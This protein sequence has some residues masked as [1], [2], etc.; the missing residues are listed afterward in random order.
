M[1]TYKLLQRSRTTDRP[2]HPRV[3]ASV[4]FMK[5]G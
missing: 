2:F 4:A 1:R 5:E 3:T